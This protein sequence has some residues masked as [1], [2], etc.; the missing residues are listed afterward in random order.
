MTN[1]QQE[2]SRVLT[3]LRVSQQNDFHF[4]NQIKVKHKTKPIV[5]WING[6]PFLSERSSLGSGYSKSI[7]DICQNQFIRI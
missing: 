6:K 3:I 5:R 2:K 1:K 7:L 4:I